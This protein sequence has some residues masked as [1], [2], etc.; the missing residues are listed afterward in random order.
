LPRPVLGALLFLT[1]LAG[2]SLVVI[3]EFSTTSHLAA[4]NE[5]VKNELSRETQD[6]QTL[7]DEKRALQGQLDFNGTGYNFEIVK[8]DLRI[9]GLQSEIEKLQY[10]LKCQKCI[11]VGLTFFWKRQLNVDAST[12]TK[13]VE[14]MDDVIWSAFCVHFFI[15]RAEPR[16]S[17]P[18]TVDCSRGNTIS[19]M[20]W[21]NEASAAR[22]E[23]DI[24][25]G[26]FQDVGSGIA[27]CTMAAGTRYAVSIAV[28]AYTPA[29]LSHEL[30]HVF[31]FSDEELTMV[32]YGIVI[33]PE[34]S[35]RIQERAKWFQ[36]RPIP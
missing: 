20:A 16:D 35:A 7:E 33:P 12:L 15:Y 6:L 3:L 18:I 8:L 22:P 1:L 31:G 17:M 36:M 34:W 26:I 25:I 4:E 2:I 27:G 23:R 24:R 21:A 5:R 14:S 10:Q 29:V 11:T 13:V 19:E 30:L 9:T 28:N 32:R